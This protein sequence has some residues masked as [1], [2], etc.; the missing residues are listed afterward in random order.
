MQAYAQ[1]RSCVEE[2]DLPLPYYE[3]LYIRR[4]ERQAAAGAIPRKPVLSVRAAGI[5]PAAR[6]EAEGF[7]MGK[8]DIGHSNN[9]RQYRTA[10]E[11]IAWFRG[12]RRGQAELIA[13]DRQAWEE[14][15]G[16]LMRQA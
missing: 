8:A 11:W 1:N 2:N 15:H 4:R 13:Q 7:L 10:E 9:P 5:S 14:K 16:P 3:F 6:A 12:W